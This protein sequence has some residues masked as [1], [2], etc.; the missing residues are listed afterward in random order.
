MVL[1]MDDIGS[2]NRTTGEHR[3]SYDEFSP[4]LAGYHVPHVRTSELEYGDFYFD[5]NGPRG[6]ETLAVGIERKTLA[7][8]MTSIRKE[9][10]SG[11][12]LPGLLEV[13]DVP[14]L[15]VEGIY[16]ACP[17]SGLLQVPRGAGQWADLRVGSTT[18][19]HSEL[20]RFLMS[21]AIMTAYA[22]GKPL[23]V[24]QSANRDA[25]ARKISD[26]YHLLTQT[27]W[28][29][30]RAHLGVHMPEITGPVML[31]KLTRDEEVKMHMRIALMGLKVGIGSDR[32]KD[33]VAHFPNAR[34]MFNADEKEWQEIPGIGK[35]IAR[36]VVDEVTYVPKVITAQ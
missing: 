28:E 23:I 14:V 15:I 6:A 18:F 20:E 32:S 16:R 31:R 24:L 21:V 11:R 3:R 12:Q 35:G 33:A 10:F 19:M 8:M 1:V 7:D 5:G 22:V 29:D 2:I 26:M 34:A 4:L 17:A 25:T 27:A 30:H 36:A 9:R 13:Y